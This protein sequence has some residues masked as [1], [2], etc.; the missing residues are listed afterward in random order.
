VVLCDRDV[1]L[2][3]HEIG[4]SGVWAA[5]DGGVLVYVH[6]ERE[7]DDVERRYRADPG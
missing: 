5:V 3:P 6:K 2:Q 4:R 1:V 7:L